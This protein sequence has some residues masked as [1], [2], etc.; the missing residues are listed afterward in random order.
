MSLKKL[1]LRVFAVAAVSSAAFFAPI[2]QAQTSMP[3]YAVV[4]PVQPSDTPDKIEVLEFFAYS[5]PHC[6][7]MEPML[8]KWAKTL[9][10]NV[11][12]RPVPVAFNASMVDLQKLYY[13][14]ESLGRLDL[15][16]EIF[17]TLHQERKPV[18]DAKAITNWVVGKGVD[19]AQFEAAFNS[20][21]I[22]TKI[23]RA[24]ELAKSYN[25]EGT[26][27]LAIGGKYVTSP[28]MTGTYESAVTEAQKL[29]EMVN[30][31]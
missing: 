18:Y 10:D 12:F 28:A 22:N 14:L 31:K 7:V 1:A 25:I 2:S 19:R 5:C 27:S 16:A 3:Q 26:P 23:K 20:F 9:P 11:V 24:D 13:A 6:A 17:K 4:D 21:G 15:H 29:V 30:K 8:A